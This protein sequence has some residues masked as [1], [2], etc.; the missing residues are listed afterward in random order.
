MRA[1]TPDAMIAAILRPFGGRAGRPVALF[2][3]MAPDTWV[4]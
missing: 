3:M 4:G 2:S 1:M